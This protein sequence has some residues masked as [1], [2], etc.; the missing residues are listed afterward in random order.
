MQA[1]SFSVDAEQQSLAREYG[2]VTYRFRW[3]GFADTQNGELHA[4]DAI[5]GFFLDEDTQLRIEWPESYELRSVEPVPTAEHTSAVSWDGSQIDFVPGEPR[6][7]VGPAGLPIGM[8]LGGGV[9]LAA[10]IV[11]GWLWLRRQAADDSQA[12]VTPTVETSK[13]RTATTTPTTQ[14]TTRTQMTVQAARTAR[15]RLTTQTTRTQPTPRQQQKP[16]QQQ[17]RVMRQQPRGRPIN[18]S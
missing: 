7:V 12:S 15:R 4:G 1:E 8:L 3:V 2:V 9:A 5:S 6:V 17:P 10:L 18:H 14:T 13:T 11:G 16:T